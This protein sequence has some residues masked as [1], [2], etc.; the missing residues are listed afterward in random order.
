M[1]GFHLPTSK[2]SPSIQPSHTLRGTAK[3]SLSSEYFHPF[4]DAPVPQDNIFKDW[5]PGD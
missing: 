1:L 5:H 2:N 3:E 4:K